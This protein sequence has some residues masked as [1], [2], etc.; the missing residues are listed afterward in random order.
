MNRPVTCD[1]MGDWAGHLL[2]YEDGR[3]AKHQFF[4]FVVHNI[5]MRKRAIEQ[6]SFLVQQKFGEEQIS[7]EALKEAVENGD[8]SVVKKLIYYAGNM[9]GGSPYWGR[10]EH[11]LRAFIKYQINEGNG[12]P[13]F[14]ATGSCAE[15]Y[16]KT[17]KRLLKNFVEDEWANLWIK[18]TRNNLF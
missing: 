2:W 6:S 17:L 12:L 4:K 9:R 5:M 3:F 10:R 14:F 15:F 8:M 7:I 11:E 16:F 18:I 13:G 1:S